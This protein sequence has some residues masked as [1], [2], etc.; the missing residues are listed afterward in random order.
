ME[1]PEK[2]DP[3]TLR[4]DFYKENIWYGK[5]ID[6]LNLRIVVRKDFQNKY[7]VVDTWYLT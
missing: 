4:M 3:V 5:I 2:G 6:K 1:D 7:M